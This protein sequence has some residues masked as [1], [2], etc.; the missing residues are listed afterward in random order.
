M[1]D[2]KT[3]VEKM[4]KKE[5]DGIIDYVEI[6]SFPKLGQVSTINEQIIIAIAVQF[7]QARLIDNMLLHPDGTKI[8]RL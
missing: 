3:E 4:L 1:S 7:E 2:I 8:D 6:L 5:T